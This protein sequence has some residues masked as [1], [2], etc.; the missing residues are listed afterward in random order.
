VSTGLKFWYKC[1]MS[2]LLIAHSVSAA[3]VSASAPFLN[4]NF[5]ARN[6]HIHTCKTASL[7]QHRR[8][9]EGARVGTGPPVEK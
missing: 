7:Y 8:L 9:Y 4:V 5:W 3:G 2:S 6:A 1:Y